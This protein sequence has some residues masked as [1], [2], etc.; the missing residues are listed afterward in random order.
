MD[1]DNL[2]D[3]VVVVVNMVKELEVV[4][5]VKEIQVEQDLVELLEQVEEEVEN[6]LEVIHQV[7]LLEDQVDQERIIVELSQVLLAQ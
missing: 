7:D 5:L 4:H 2:E 1:Q 3:Q 6:L